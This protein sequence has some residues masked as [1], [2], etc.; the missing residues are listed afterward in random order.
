L[1]GFWD[2]YYAAVLDY[3]SPIVNFGE[4]IIVKGLETDACRELATQPMA[5]LGIS[6]ESDELVKQ[7]ITDTG[8]RA[9][10][11]ATV[12]HEMLTQLPT[13]RRVFNATE[14]TTALHSQAVE[15]SL[16]SWGQ[17]SGDQHAD[18]LDR[19]IVYATVEQDE[20]TITDVMEVLNAHQQGY[21]PEQLKQSLERLESEKGGLTV[22]DVME[23]LNVRQSVYSSEQLTQSLKR[24]E[25]AYI[26]QRDEGTYRY[27]V[28]LFREWL[29]EDDVNGLL[30]QEFRANR[31]T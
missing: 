12:C 29:L 14:V 23:L 24:L 21:T 10:L 17:L 30:E 11:I 3:H 16:A 28:P 6:Y 1:A 9:N 15:E 7:I 31:L 5:L 20:F 26:I 2:F 4:T 25:L 13:D 27:C 22:T 19:I 8:Q 18:C